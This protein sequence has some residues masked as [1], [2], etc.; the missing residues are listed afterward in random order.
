MMVGTF[1]VSHTPR[2]LHDARAGTAAQIAVFWRTLL[3][4]DRWAGR[5]TL[6]D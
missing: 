2:T 3:P 6:H 4:D 1:T 5:L